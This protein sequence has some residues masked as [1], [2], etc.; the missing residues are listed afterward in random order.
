[1]SR[2]LPLLGIESDQAQTHVVNVA[3][4]ATNCVSAADSTPWTARYRLA[5]SSIL[6]QGRDHG[7]LDQERQ[8]GGAME[9]TPELLIPGGRGPKTAAGV[10]PKTGRP[11][12]APGATEVRWSLTVC[13]SGATTGV[14][15]W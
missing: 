8:A 15:A 1:M 14:G 10:G 9:A 4:S 3:H 5:W 6:Q 11:A 7:A 12:G 2:G 13:S